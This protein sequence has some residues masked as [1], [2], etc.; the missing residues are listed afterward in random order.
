MIL[1]IVDKERIWVKWLGLLMMIG[2]SEEGE[3]DPNE[4]EGKG[5]IVFM[6]L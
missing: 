6:F 5:L 1:M 3:R 2:R 4:Y